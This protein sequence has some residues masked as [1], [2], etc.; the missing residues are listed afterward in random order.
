SEQQRDAAVS[1]AEHAARAVADREARV[2]DLSRP[3][4]APQLPRRLD[5][6]EDAAHAGM[7]RGEAAA[8][9]GPGERAAETDPA[10]AD[11]AAA[12]A[13]SAEAEALERGE[14]GDRVRVVDH[15]EVDVGV[16]RAG[17]GEGE[18]ARLA[19]RDVEQVAPAALGV[20]DRL[21]TAEDHHG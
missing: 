7:V 13:R 2:R 11:E 14:D 3:A 18:R 15:R 10:A 6:E 19:R 1:L 9:G 8:V 17:A 5:D 20:A 21:G 12:L 16:A 4:L